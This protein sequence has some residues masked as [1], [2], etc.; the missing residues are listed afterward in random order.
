VFPLS[1]LSNNPTLYDGSPS[2]I[3]LPQAS[4]LKPRQTQERHLRRLASP[5]IV[6]TSQNG[7]TTLIT[8]TKRSFARTA[9]ILQFSTH[10]NAVKRSNLGSSTTAT[11]TTSSAATKTH[12]CDVT[13]PARLQLSCGSS[14]AGADGRPHAGLRSCGD[15]IIM[16]TGADYERTGYH[17]DEESV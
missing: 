15:L 14:Q 7:S 16:L 6:Q 10:I 12:R 8:L 17:T 9:H 5:Q 11:T 4:F 2:L 1:S 3:T 13:L